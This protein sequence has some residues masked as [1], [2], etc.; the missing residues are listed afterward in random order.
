LGKTAIS[1]AAS[2]ILIDKNLV[3]G[4]LV[5]APLRPARL[6]WPAEVQKW[7]QFKDLDMVLLHGKDKD[8]LLAEKHDIYVIN[9]EG[10][11]WLF[12][13]TFD[14]R[15]AKIKPALLSKLMQK[16]DMLIIDESTKFKSSSSQRF[17]IMKATLTAWR[18]RYI[19]T[20]TPA[21]NGI[22]DLWAQIYLLDGGAS[23]GQYVTHFRNSYFYLQ[24]GSHQYD[25]RMF[26]GAEE[27]VAEKISH[28]VMRLK[29]EDYIQMPE[30]QFNRIE[31]ELA[32]EI[33]A[34]YRELEKEFILMLEEGV[35]TAANAAVLGNKLRQAV[36]GALYLPNGGGKAQ[37]HT[38]KPDALMELVEE[39]SGQPLLIGYDFVF[40]K[41]MIKEAVPHVQF[42]D[43]K[44]DEEL[45]RL[46]NLGM[47][48]ALAGN[49]A[50]VGHGLNLQQAC[51]H[52]AY[53]SLTWNLE[54]FDQFIRRVR[55]QGNP[56]KRIICH[57]IMTKD[58]VDEAVWS[59]L[60]S[61]ELTQNNLLSHL[62]SRF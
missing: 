25:L 24:P 50:S 59:A 12:E 21:P 33:R 5:I 6:T 11:P 7:E 4:V 19:L 23:L 26:P 20:G 14:K 29:A 18:R 34:Q 35:V 28:L 58:T 43:G 53:T 57:L 13:P 47:I 60:T 46:F 55:R 56:N 51:C 22:E 10:L 17:K 31:T 39:L 3:K 62:R 45:I 36:A 30:L 42:L 40:E 61:K 37:L 38:T 44:N 32:P 52:V 41:E 54:N 9:P 16:F 49:P 1:L 48:P 8:K 2:K 15:S 27:K